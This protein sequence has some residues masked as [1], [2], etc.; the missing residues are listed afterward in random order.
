[1][2]ARDGDAAVANARRFDT[3]AVGMCLQFVRG[4]GWEIGA[5]YGSAIDAWHGAMDRHPGDRNPPR[6]APC[7]Y[8]GGQYGH[9]V[10]CTEPGKDPRRMRST[11]APTS[12]R[13]SEQDLS[14]PEQAWND[15]YLGWTGDLNGVDLPLGG[16]EMNDDDWKRLR[17]IVRE[18]VWEKSLPVNKPDGSETKKSAGQI[19][20]ETLQR[21]QK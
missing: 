19:I 8:S 6:G 2:T 11:D 16:D 12:G 1:M 21:V 3:Y 13:V 14:W 10:L 18:E 5:L 9:I 4:E 15:D 20:R 17:K 7:F